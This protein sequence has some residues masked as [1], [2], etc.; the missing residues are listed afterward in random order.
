MAKKFGKFLLAAAA[1]GSA[2]AAVYFY[3]QKKDAVRE[4]PE[5][6]DYDDFTEDLDEEKGTPRTYVSLTESDS[7]ACETED[8]EK[9]FTPLTEQIAKASETAEEAVEEFFDEEDSSQ[10]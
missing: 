8:E 2:A 3:K 10:A 1:V 5:D 7:Q 9:D 6:E 4:L